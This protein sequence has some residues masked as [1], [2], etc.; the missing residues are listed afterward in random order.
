MIARR[1]ILQV[2]SLSAAHGVLS[3]SRNEVPPGRTPIT[4]WFSYGG[5]NREVLEAL[6]RRFNH[7]QARDYVQAVYQGDYFEGLAKLR[8]ALA[9]GAAPAAQPRGGRSRAVLGRSRRARAARRLPGARAACRCIPALG[10]SRFVCGAAETAAGG[11]LPF[12]RS[13]PIAYVNQT[14]L[15]RPASGARHLARAARGRR[16]RSL[17]GRGRFGFGCP[18]DW[19]YWVALVGQAGGEVVEPD[20]RVSLGDQ[21]GVRAL[22]LVADAWSTTAR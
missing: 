9:V 11:A 15:R 5:R 19:W 1:E 8:T 2:L 17:S 3:C 16:A 14:L 10:A 20:G 21:A 6:V 22:A 18:I 7:G 12:N 13:T 4:L